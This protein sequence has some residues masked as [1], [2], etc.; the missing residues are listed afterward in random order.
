MYTAA[1]LF[2]VILTSTVAVFALSF[3]AV[4][5]SSSP[6]KGVNEIHQAHGIDVEFPRN[7]PVGFLG[8]SRRI[9]S[10]GVKCDL[11]LQRVNEI[12]AKIKTMDVFMESKQVVVDEKIGVIDEKLGDLKLG[13]NREYSSPFP[14]PPSF[15]PP[16]LPFPRLPPSFPIPPDPPPMPP[17]LPPSPTFPPFF[18]PSQPSLIV[19]TVDIFW[20]NSVYIFLM[21]ISICFVSLICRREIAEAFTK[22]AAKSGALF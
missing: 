16:F 22:C 18:P 13:W 1:W 3:A 15:P 20:D 21:L 10:C 6:H 8:H 4:L 17:S 5:K 2:R 14:R 12:Y 19:L 11:I 9:L 7:L